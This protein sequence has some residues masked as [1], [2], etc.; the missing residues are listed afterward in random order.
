MKTTILTLVCLFS[1]SA[2]SQDSKINWEEIARQAAVETDNQFTE[3]FT[4]ADQAFSQIAKEAAKKTDEQ[5]S[6]QIFE[7]TDPGHN[8]LDE[9]SFISELELA[10]LSL[11]SLQ[12]QLLSKA[13]KKKYRRR[14]R[15]KLLSE[16]AELKMLLNCR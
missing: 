16:A 8:G 3:L 6:Q 13:S 15:K 14:D 4:Q 11:T 7:L 9:I 12:V 5:L 2:F 1:I 10:C